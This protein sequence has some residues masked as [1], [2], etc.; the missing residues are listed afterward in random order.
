MSCNFCETI[1]LSEDH[2]RTKFSNHWDERKAIV[3]EDGEPYLYIPCD[4]P[5]YSGTVMQ[6]NYCPKC[7]RKLVQ[8]TNTCAERWYVKNHRLNKGDC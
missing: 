5:Y 8:T 6:I 3:I 1:W 4:D 7:G 2:Y